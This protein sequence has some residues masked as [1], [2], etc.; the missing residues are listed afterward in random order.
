VDEVLAVGDIG[1]QRK[2]FG[3][4]G[5]VA[6][7]GKTVLLVSHDLR[8]IAG[9]ASRAAL[10]DA[11]KMIALGPTGAVIPQYLNLNKETGTHFDKN[12]FTLSDIELDTIQE[13]AQDRQACLTTGD[14]V[15]LKF[16]IGFQ[17]LCP[18]TSVYVQLVDSLA[19]V[20]YTSLSADNPQM[21][22]MDFEAGH[23]HFRFQAP[24]S[25]AP[26][27]YWVNVGIL[28]IHQR[29]KPLIQFSRIF[30]FEV[31]ERNGNV[32]DGRFGPIYVTG[33]WNVHPLNRLGGVS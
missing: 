8:A 24:L 11:G 3:K 33:S 12:G 7:S 17:K 16:C 18:E 14:P 25:L 15:V 13:S 6:E 2:C 27:T 9:L 21:D 26:G 28:N 19:R 31:L 20:V 30:S 29:R 10:F 23:Y 4:I 5:D 32:F 1:F 22:W